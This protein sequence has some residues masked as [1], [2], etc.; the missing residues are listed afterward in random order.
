MFLKCSTCWEMLIKHNDDKYWGFFLRYILVIVSTK[1]KFKSVQEF[2]KWQV[3]RRKRRNLT[4]FRAAC[5]S[6]GKKWSVCTNVYA[7][8]VVGESVFYWWKSGSRILL[9]KKKVGIVRRNDK[10]FWWRFYEFSHV[11][12][13]LYASKMI[14]TKSLSNVQIFQFRIIQ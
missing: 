4:I 2:Y 12:K 11:K 8:I 9:W 1:D 3:T 10:A 6:K 7:A 5:W 14:E 13:W